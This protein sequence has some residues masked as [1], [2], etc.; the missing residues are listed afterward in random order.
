MANDGYRSIEVMCVND[1]RGNLVVQGPGIGSNC[2]WIQGEQPSQGDPINQYTSS[3]WGVCTNNINASASG[4]IELTGLGSSPVVIVFAN[5]EAG[6]STCTVT[7]NDAVTA[8]VTQNDT[9]ELNHSSFSVQLIP[10][11]NRDIANR[12]LR[13]LIE[14]KV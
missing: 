2:T 7:G 10:N 5:N 11:S 3:M 6:Q 8:I 13:S 4:H 1:T 9:S 14:S 12:P